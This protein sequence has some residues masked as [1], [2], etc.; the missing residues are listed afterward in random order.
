MI[1]LILVERNKLCIIFWLKNHLVEK[2]FKMWKIIILA[3]CEINDV[4]AVL[5]F[6]GGGMPVF[7]LI[8]RIF[9][10]IASKSRFYE[11]KLF[12]V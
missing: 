9:L 7:Y 12:L 4:A 5:G 8:D 1:G 6:F 3:W 2:N 10:F 11:K